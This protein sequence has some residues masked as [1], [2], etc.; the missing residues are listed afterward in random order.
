MF[1]HITVGTNNLQRAIAFYDAVLAT[2]GQE[3]GKSGDT[4]AAY[5]DRAGARFFVMTP[6]DGAE[7]TTG[8]GVHVAFAA[9]TPAH[10]DAFHAAALAHGGTDEGAPGLRPRYHAKYYGGYIRDPDGNKL[11]AVCHQAD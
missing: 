3:R 5:G 6:F 4:F 11:Q 8:N 2:L 7:A 9:P 1:G 10:V